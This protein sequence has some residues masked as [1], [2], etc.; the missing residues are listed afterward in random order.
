[1]IS[2]ASLIVLAALLASPPRR[3]IA[4]MTK[5][6]SRRAGRLVRS[7]PGIDVRPI[8]DQDGFRACVELQR[9]TW[10]RT[11]SDVVPVSMLQ[12]TAKMGGVVLGAF[13]PDG[14]LIG[15]VYGVTGFR[16]GAAAHWSHMLAVRPEARNAGVGQ[17]LKRCQKETLLTAGV[18][19][20]Y[21]TFD[22]LVSRNA[23]LNLNRLGARVTEYVPEMYGTSDS[24]LHDLGTDRFVVEWRLE[25]ETGDASSGAASDRSKRASRAFEPLPQN[26]VEV[27]IPA[28]IETVKSRSLKEA[29]DWRKSTR[30]AFTRLLAEGREVVAFVPGPEQSK[31]VVTPIDPAKGAAP[32]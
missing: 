20:M 32:K 21:W 15:F 11:F 25:E 27:S 16:H 12:V 6:S 28:D 5:P 26:A 1:M 2:H 4:P 9:R 18:G 22:P 10:G 23:H 17:R 8:E 31:Y 19:M 7:E 13:D 24:D 30:E 29:M 14:E 3:R